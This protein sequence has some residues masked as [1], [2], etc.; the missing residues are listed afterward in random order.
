[1]H[2]Q[3]FAQSRQRQARALAEDAQHGELQAGDAEAFAQRLIEVL[4]GAVEADPGD[5]G[6]KGLLLHKDLKCSIA[7]SGQHIMAS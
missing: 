2:H 3:R 5:D 4:D 7:S 6:G 1:M